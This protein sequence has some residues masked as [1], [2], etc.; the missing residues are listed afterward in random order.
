MKWRF[1]PLA[2]VSAFVIQMALSATGIGGYRDLR[3]KQLSDSLFAEGVELYDRGEYADAAYFFYYCD[4]IDKESLDSLSTR[5]IYAP[6]WLAACFA[7][8]GDT[9]TALKVCNDYL[10]PED[11]RLTVEQD[12]LFELGSLM[13]DIGDPQSALRYYQMAAEAQIRNIGEVSVQNCYF[14]RICAMASESL[15]DYHKAMEYQVKAADVAEKVF[16][17]N[18]ARTLEYIKKLEVY[19]NK[20]GELKLAKE[21]S[22]KVCRITKF[23]Y[24]EHCIEYLDAL[25]SECLFDTYLGN[26][27]DA[28]S[29]GTKCLALMEELGLANSIYGIP[30]WNNVSISLTEVGDV[31][32]AMAN[33]VKAESL[34]ES[35]KCDDP[36]L[37]CSILSNLASCHNKLGEYDKAL[38]LSRKSLEIEEANGLSSARTLNNISTYYINSC[39]YQEVIDILESELSKPESES[40]INREIYA[41]MLGNLSVAYG[42]VGR[43]KDALQLNQNILELKAAIY[44]Y[45][46]PHCAL[47]LNNISSTCTKLGN[48]DDAEDYAN[49]ALA[50]QREIFGDRHTETLRTLH[51]LAKIYFDKG[52]YSQGISLSRYVVNLMKDV[53]GPLHPEYAQY[54]NSLGMNYAEMGNYDKAL[55]AVG[56]A[57]EIWYISFGKNSYDYAL[58]LNNISL[59]YSYQGRYEEAID[60]SREAMEL[61]DSIMGKSNALYCSSLGN[62]SSYCQNIGKL[63]E[64]VRYAEES[65]TLRRAIFGENHPDVALTM[66]NLATIYLLSGN[67]SKAVEMQR[68]SAEIFRQCLGEDHP[69]YAVAINNLVY[70]YLDLDG[71]KALDYAE[72]SNRLFR[73]IIL[74]NFSDMTLEE[75]GM[76]WNKF[77]FWYEDG[78]PSMA[79][80]YPCDRTIANGYDG[81]LLAKGVLLNS[82]RQLRQLVAESNDAELLQIYDRL[83]DVRAEHDRL[84]Q[85]GPERGSV[86]PDSLA[87]MADD[88]ERELATRSKIYGDFTANMSIDWKRVRDSLE[89]GELAVEF[90][91][92]SLNDRTQYMAY[93]LKREWEMPRL[94]TLCTDL[95]IADN[96]TKAYYTPG[97]SR[98]IWA[99]I[100]EAAGDVSKI[101]FAPSGELY[102]IAIEL[103]ADPRDPEQIISECIPM[104]RLS[105]TR[106]LAVREGSRPGNHAMIYGDLDYDPDM[107]AF[108]EAHEASVSAEGQSAL[109]ASRDVE[110]I[111]EDLR[112]GVAP[113]PGTRQEVLY[114][115]D[116]LE[117][118]NMSHALYRGMD[119]TEE[120]LKQANGAAPWLLH[121]GTH[122]FFD[123]GRSNSRLSGMF[124]AGPDEKRISEEE[125]A[126]MRSGL[127][128]SGANITLRGDTLPEGME[129]G[130]LTA[131][132]I[133]RMDLRG[134]DMVVLSA[135]QTALGEISGDGVFGLQ[136]GFKKAGAG[137]ILMSLW[138]VN[139]KATSLLMQRFYSLLL[140]GVSK[141]KALTEARRY[142]REYRDEKGRRP[143]AAPIFW[144][145]FILLD[146]D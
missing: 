95:E 45:K 79:Y 129:D 1:I 87:R 112:Q 127:L 114:L 98:V 97:L 93:L 58:S 24:G 111:A 71:D 44:G 29:T 135:C 144:A 86:D 62:M 30:I 17:E 65:L 145:S 76:F 57:S 47:V 16:G 40:S 104:S 54:L 106:Q 113:L 64:S 139:D 69:L 91:S 53:A 142:V 49:R 37:L 3:S 56:E 115:N 20:V 39:H 33:L 60:K 34:F 90:V 120:S 63:E 11:R 21:C 75:R 84:I 109:Y 99:P 100:L 116:L 133:S 48:Y 131:L 134:A 7:N 72:V 46:S 141:N 22:A 4:S 5:Q 78:L 18:S 123:D 92:F 146:A 103:M 26:Y 70:D 143:Y 82:D 124:G 107:T 101:Y 89:E 128:F 41:S 12:S 50:I 32:S 15:G 138:K 96:K 132:E 52:D 122:G 10:L 27:Q 31:S 42:Q 121:I 25:N 125:I 8:L 94:V 88:L 102:N 13:N 2:F 126:M 118:R 83:R 36:L 85:S 66:N 68:E 38:E 73:N 130:I 140:D 74:R 110:F 61:V 55:S 136:R 77:L 67:K 28:I 23:L 137:S 14:Q 119:G 117:K 43:Y 51:N 80:S 35:Q 59:I 9:V 105:S 81:I 19:C 108:R 6:W